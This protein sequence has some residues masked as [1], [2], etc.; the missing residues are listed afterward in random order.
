M[1]NIQLL[2]FF[3]YI[4]LTFNSKV[5]GADSW[6][7]PKWSEMIEGSDLIALVE[8]TS[9]GEFEAK[10]KV[11]TIYKGE[12]AEKEIWISGY[13]NKFGPIN[14][15][16]VGDRFIVFLRQYLVNDDSAEYL[17]EQLKNE[18]EREEYIN[19][20]KSDNAYGVWTPTAGFLKITGE[21]VK[22]NLIRTTVDENNEF[23]SLNEF[24]TFLRVLGE[25]NKN[26]FHKEILDR[27]NDQTDH[28][29]LTQYLM[30]LSLSNFQSFDPI[31]AEIIK[32]KKTE[33]Y[34]ALARLLGQ[35]EN[36][37]ATQL[38]VKLLS[39]EN[40]LVQ[41]EVVRQLK[42]RELDSIGPILVDH[43]SV[44]GKDG[45]YT[46]NL[47]SPT[48]SEVHGGLIET[49]IALA[50]I[51]YKP[52]VPKLL[53]FL[54]TE[55]KSLFELVIN[56]I[57]YL[58]STDYIPH[59][60]DRLR[61]GNR[62]FMFIISRT[63][64]K[65]NLEECIYPLMSFINSHDKSIYPSMDYT[66][67]KHMGL[68]NFESDTVSQFL[69]QD[70]LS[71]LEMEDGSGISSKRNWVNSYTEVFTKL[72]IEKAKPH[73]YNHMITNYGFDTRFKN[74]P[75]FF[76][77]K[78]TLEDSIATSVHSLF[79]NLNKRDIDV[80]VYLN[81]PDIQESFNYSIK[82]RTG[83]ENFE[84]IRN[85]LLTHGFSGGF[86]TSSGGAITLFN[87]PVSHLRFAETSMT[88]FLKFI[89][90]FPDMNDIIFLENLE[91][92]NYAESDFDD[93]QLSNFIEIAKKNLQANEGN[94]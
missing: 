4:L 57:H 65:N 38:L 41:G 49:I 21:N 13:S 11:L 52:A 93:R 61:S 20:L 29:K 67:S 89:S 48:M 51:G 45:L 90:K 33:T 83:Q 7:D 47:M 69:F 6:T 27:L 84:R 80:R 42:N 40:S 25:E 43:L 28:R 79:D 12:V 78:Q 36:K 39:S 35:I 94:N 62:D 22:Y 87:G 53:P 72:G 34:F 17:N 73:L 3:V 77:I 37:K 70:F 23:Y 24:E 92:F 68:A 2:I 26:W 60:N 9:S 59:I 71:V 14:R 31:F 64:A 10:A 88:N 19:A 55:D 85:G 54:E 8:F 50:E 58:G 63:I 81:A 32:D 5:L 15:K 1:K 66:I 91:K 56:V 75:K 86:V 82:I 44:A 16:R 18:P 74:E 76:E 46:S 30:M